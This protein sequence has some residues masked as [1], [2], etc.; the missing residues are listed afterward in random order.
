MALYI[1]Y[2]ADIYDI[3]LKYFSPEDIHIYSIDEVFI[4]LTTY[5]PFY[6]TDAFSL[7]KKVVDDIFDSTGIT[8]TVGIAPNLFLC[9]VAMEQG[10]N[11]CPQHC[12]A[13][14][15]TPGA[16]GKPSSQFSLNN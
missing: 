13:D 3:Y 11:S 12:K 10:S 8:A 4:D 1:K 5:L 15:L 16:P 14:S 6:N 9:K 7:C 2:S